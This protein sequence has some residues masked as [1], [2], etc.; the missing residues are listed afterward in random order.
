[1]ITFKVILWKIERSNLVSGTYIAYIACY[2]KKKPSKRTKKR[3][4]KSRAVFTKIV[5]AIKTRGSKGP[6]YV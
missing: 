3:G 6:S 5:K 4:P 2:V 1:M